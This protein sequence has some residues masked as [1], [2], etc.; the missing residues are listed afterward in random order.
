MKQVKIA[1]IGGAIAALV[2]MSAIADN[3]KQAEALEGALVIKSQDAVAF[4]PVA[5]ETQRV[6]WAKAPIKVD[7]DLADWEAN[8]I[9]S[10]V[11]DTARSS[12]RLTTSADTTAI[13]AR[14]T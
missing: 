7:G 6:A 3:V 14:A 10:R 13:P 1:F 9:K 12:R 11:F 8:G 4:V 5:A 2:G